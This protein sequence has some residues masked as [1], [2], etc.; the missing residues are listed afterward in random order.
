MRTHGFDTRHLTV[1]SAVVIP[2]AATV[3]RPRR[4]GR[5]ADTTMLTR[6][7]IR[8]PRLRMLPLAALL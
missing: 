5:Q 8:H 1:A 7:L 3:S 4:D 6:R 2:L